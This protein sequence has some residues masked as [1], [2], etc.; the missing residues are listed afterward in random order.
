MTY[1]PTQTC[2]SSPCAAAAGYVLPLCV[3][4]H[5]SRRK[6]SGLYLNLVWQGMA[7][8]G[9]CF[10]GIRVKGKLERNHHFYKNMATTH[11]HV[12][13]NELR[14][15]ANLFPPFAD[16]P[17]KTSEPFQAERRLRRF[18][19]RGTLERHRLLRRDRDFPRNVSR[20]V[21][22]AWM[23]GLTCW[24]LKGFSIKPLKV[25]VLAGEKKAT[26]SRLEHR[27]GPVVVG[28]GEPWHQ[29]LRA[30]GFLG[31]SSDAWNQA[32]ATSFQP[33]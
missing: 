7:T 2:A 1:K 24:Q 14:H 31:R 8:V 12:E 17:R 22:F 13:I 29:V 33:Y 4:R 15:F 19:Q 32:R 11:T 23:L 9:V 26:E 3:R 28:T 18:E 27:F 30:Y 6:F 20:S 21:H 16:S 25:K 10:E 5:T